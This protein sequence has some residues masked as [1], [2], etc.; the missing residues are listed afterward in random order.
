ME[1]LA[2]IKCDSL[3]DNDGDSSKENELNRNGSDDSKI[4]GPDT[5]LILSRMSVADMDNFDRDM[6]LIIDFY[7]GCFSRLLIVQMLL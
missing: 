4:A 2:S 7:F 1:L 5:S 3:I 6:A